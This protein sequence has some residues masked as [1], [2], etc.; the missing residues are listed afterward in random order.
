MSIW[1]QTMRSWPDARELSLEEPAVCDR[2]AL[3]PSSIT[4]NLAPAFEER[5]EPILEEIRRERALSNQL[6]LVPSIVWQ[7]LEEG[8]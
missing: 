8:D 2:T 7:M 3:E 1:D 4:F 6:A 5:L